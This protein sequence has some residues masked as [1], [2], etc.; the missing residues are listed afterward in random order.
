MSSTNDD[1]VMI[2]AVPKKGRM[3]D[4]CD[5]VLKGAGLKYTRA[6]RLDIAYVKDFPVPLKIVFLPAKDIAQFVGLGNVDLGLTGQ[7][8]V[9]EAEVEVNEL[10][11]TGF[12]KCKLCVQAPVKDKITDIN[13]LAGKRIV[14]SFPALTRQF[15]KPI[16]EKAGT[17]TSIRLLSGSVEAACGLGLADAV[18]DLVET[19]TTMRAAG[20]EVVAEVIDTEAVLISNPHS[21]HAAMVEKIRKR[22]HGYLFAQRYMMMYYNINRDGLEKASKS[23]PGRLAPNVTPLDDGKTVSVGAMVLSADVSKVMDELE[24]IGA[25]DIFVVDIHNCRA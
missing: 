23:T 11:K 25:T 15:F 14:T 19:G 5:K 17:T 16:D 6:P 4:Q 3:F 21:K 9:A 13:T 7:D 8:M 12:G 1:D 18:V 10:L 2:M 20:L 24:A 22:I